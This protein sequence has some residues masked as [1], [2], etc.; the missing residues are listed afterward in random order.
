[1]QNGKTNVELRLENQEEGVIRE[2]KLYVETMFGQL[3][4]SPVF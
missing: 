1:M 3:L 4:G 2:R